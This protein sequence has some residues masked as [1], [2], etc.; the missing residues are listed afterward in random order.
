[1]DERTIL[2]LAKLAGVGITPEQVPAV[3]ESLRRTAQIAQPLLEAKLEPEDE[4][5]PVWRP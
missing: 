1:M 4:P 5:A 2:E 3:L